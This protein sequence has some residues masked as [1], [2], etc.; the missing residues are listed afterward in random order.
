MRVPEALFCL[1]MIIFTAKFLIPHHYYYYSF[2][3][4]KNLRDYNLYKWRAEE[5]MFK[6]SSEKK[7]YRYR[8]VRFALLRQFR[9]SQQ[10]GNIHIYI[11]S[12][13]VFLLI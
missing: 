13:D 6:N 8:K 10:M 1:S 4:K 12:K 3:F 11:L 5:C 2:I 9:D 7:N